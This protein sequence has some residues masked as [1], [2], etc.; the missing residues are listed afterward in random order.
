MR[1]RPSDPRGLMSLME[2]GMGDQNP[3]PPG[4]GRLSGG[5]AF[6]IFVRPSGLVVV[7][8]AQLR[9]IQRR[10]RR[11]QIGR[12]AAWASQRIATRRAGLLLAALA[13]A[14]VAVWPATL[15]D[16]AA[17]SA[18]AEANRPLI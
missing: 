18:S 15:A 7:D 10:R 5:V 9:A 11:Q 14:C 1:R 12:G 17:I 8:E 6:D 2:V 13:L 4:P 16:A 3:F